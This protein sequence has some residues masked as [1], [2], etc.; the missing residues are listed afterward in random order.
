MVT[1]GRRSDWER[2][3]GARNRGSRKKRTY[4][5]VA[6]PPA[7]RSRNIGHVGNRQRCPVTVCCT[8]IVRT[9][10]CYG[11]RC[12][13]DSARLSGRGARRFKI[14]SRVPTMLVGSVWYR[15]WSGS[16]PPPET[17]TEF[18]KRLEGGLGRD[19]HR[20]LNQRITRQRSKSIGACASERAQNAG[21]SRA[22]RWPSRSNLRASYPPPF[23][24]LL[25]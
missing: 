3:V 20:H 9:G 12:R 21:P 1:F 14:V 8:R 13:Q 17:V 24:V 25:G 10:V 11:N 5:P 16:P 19:I 2:R 15:C 18:V 22:G 23:T 6:P 7:W 4:H